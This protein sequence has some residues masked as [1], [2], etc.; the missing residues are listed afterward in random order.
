MS[1]DHHSWFHCGHCGSLFQSHLGE[2]DKRICPFCGSD[3]SLGVEAVSNTNA[4]PLTATSHGPNRSSVRKRKSN[5]FLV[6]LFFG[7]IVF[8]GIVLFVAR[9]MW[10]EQG[11]RPSPPAR[12]AVVAR[13]V[14]EENTALLNEASPFCIQVFLGYLAART[15]EERNQ[16]V[17]KPITTAARMNRFYTEN[18]SIN[19]DPQTLKLAHSSVI[20]FPS[21]PAIESHWTSSE[22]HR[23][24]SVFMK[25]ND[26]WRLDWDHFARYSD[27]PWPLFLA[28]SGDPFSEFRLLARERLAEERKNADT[29]SIVLYAPRFGYTM[30]LGFQSPEFLIKRDSKNGRL[31][32]AAFK[33]EKENK[34]V[35]GAQF[36][37]NNPEGFIRVRAK[38]RRYE[39]NEE[40]RFELEEVLACHW[41]SVDFPGVEIQEKP[42]TK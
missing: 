4:E 12:Q 34:R 5:Y 38:V 23:L 21:G 9:R 15:P 8:I 19:F 26:E 33:L 27:Y 37:N 25:E 16:F 22:G 28:G 17:L 2:S 30:E 10:P 36:P 14:L 7:W 13:E 29:I 24:D 6:K 41:Y 11:A 42:V 35:F 31:L 18:P 3:P 39:E 20:Q 40:R 1:E 32:E